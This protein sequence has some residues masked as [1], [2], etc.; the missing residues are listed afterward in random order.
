MLQIF[1]WW[2]NQYGPFRKTKKKSCERTFELINM[3]DNMSPQL[4]IMGVWALTENGDEQFWKEKVHAANG[5]A[6]HALMMGPDFFL[7]KQ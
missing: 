1:W 5:K 4:C 7:L 3:Y 2:A 6:W